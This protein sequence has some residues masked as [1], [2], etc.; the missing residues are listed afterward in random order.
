MSQTD[1]IN[2]N[3]GI[4]PQ[5]SEETNP[6][7]IPQAN[8]NIVTPT[9]N[10]I[11]LNTISNTETPTSFATLISSKNEIVTD[12]NCCTRIDYS[13]PELGVCQKSSIIVF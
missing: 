4:A 10:D 11:P 12:D 1:N 9:T 13:L 6:G 3:V 8:R 5:T 7:F 2:I